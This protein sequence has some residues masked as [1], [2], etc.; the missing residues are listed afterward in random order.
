MHINNIYIKIHNNR[1]SNT[2][3]YIGSEA[4]PAILIYY[5]A[6]IVSQNFIIKERIS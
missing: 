5:N 6:L 3:I 2:I 1:K 4:T